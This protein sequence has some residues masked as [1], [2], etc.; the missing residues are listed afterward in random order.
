MNKS[1]NVRTPYKH[2]YF[3]HN[4]GEQIKMEEFRGAHSFRHCMLL[5]GRIGAYAML[6]G[7]A[8]IPQDVI[9]SNLHKPWDFKSMSCNRYLKWDLVALYPH[10]AWDWNELSKHCRLEHSFYIKHRGLPWNL[11]VMSTNRPY[12][13]NK[14]TWM[15]TQ[16]YKRRLVHHFRKTTKLGHMKSSGYIQEHIMRKVIKYM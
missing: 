15:R 14:S 5:H 11:N 7:T 1:C 6:S 2:T 10:F 16:E 8:D 4:I 12:Q 9:L 3:S 13:H